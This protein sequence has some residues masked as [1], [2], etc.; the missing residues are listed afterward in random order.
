MKRRSIKITRYIIAGMAAAAIVL[1][2]AK[3][4]TAS[5]AAEERIRE[6]DAFIES[7]EPRTDF[8]STSHEA[9]T[10]SLSYEVWKEESTEEPEQIVT[11]TSVD[12][13]FLAEINGSDLT[14]EEF[15]EAGVL[16]WDGWKYTW[17]S[18]NVLP[19]EGLEIPGRWSDGD[20]V[21][22]YEGYLCVACNDLEQGTVVATPWGE[23]KVYDWIGDGITGGIDVYT[24]W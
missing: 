19:G 3:A 11:E 13:D 8:A 23:A 16:Y 6:T 12:P 9:E 17:Y 15:R 10:V 22:D 24:S 14:P 5:A 2:I 21:R 20:F 7:Y 1:L 4:A 18:E